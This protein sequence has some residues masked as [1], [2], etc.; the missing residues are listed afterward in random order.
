MCKP[1][2]STQVVLRKL[3][4]GNSLIWSY[5]FGWLESPESY[6]FR[7]ADDWH[8]WSAPLDYWKELDRSPVGLLFL[9][10]AESYPR[11]VIGWRHH[12]LPHM[13]PPVTKDFV[14]PKF[15]YMVCA[16]GGERIYNLGGK[17]PC[18]SSPP[19]F[20]S[21]IL[22]A[23][24]GYIWMKR[25]IWF[26]HNSTWTEKNYICLMDSFLLILRRVVLYFM[27]IYAKD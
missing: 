26:N 16:K 15:P 5:C 13:A 3:E 22:Y 1:V 7:L 2:P 18:R 6:P 20:L 25:R 27:Q 21:K 9:G 19:D 17:E 23:G 12:M 14:L 4:R 24:W 11:L 10:D 8:L